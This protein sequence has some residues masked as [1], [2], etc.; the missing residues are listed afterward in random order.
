[1]KRYLLFI[2]L[3]AILMTTACGNTSNNQESGTGDGIPTI[4]E[5]EILLPESIEPN[6]EVKIEALVTQG[7]EKVQDANEVMFEVWQQGQEV[8]HEMIEATNDG[9]GIYS[10][11]KTFEE[12]GIYYIVAHTTARD[13]HVMPRIEVTVG[14]PEPSESAHNHEEHEEHAHGEHSAGHDHD[15]QT[16]LVMTLEKKGTLQVEEETILSVTIEQE[17]AAFTDAEVLFEVW[18]DGSDMHE[19]LEAEEG[20]AGVYEAEATFQNTGKHHVQI[21]VKKGELHEHQLDMIE[22]E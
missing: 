6:E 11:T 12:E 4:V 10:F 5:V 22:V 13:M 1:M 21:H 16:T 9:S 17:K 2:S 19:Y 7:E 20:S 8:D 15:H 18:E 14:H 3:I